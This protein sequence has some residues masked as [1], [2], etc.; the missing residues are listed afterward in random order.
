MQEDPQDVCTASALID[1]SSLGVSMSGEPADFRALFESAPSPF[2]VLDPEFV[3]VAASDAYLKATK[4]ERAEIVGQGV[5]DVFPDNPDD[6]AT[7]GVRNLRALARPR[8]ARRSGRR[9]GGPEVRRVP[10][11]EAEGGGFEERYWSPYNS[12]V[13]APDRYW[14]SCASRCPT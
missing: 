5:F 12:P 10:R 9:H 3:I 6:P 7:E 14:P 2:L 1:P 13:F 11:P 4:T 8:A